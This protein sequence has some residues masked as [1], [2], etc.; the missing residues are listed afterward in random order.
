[1]KIAKHPRQKNL[2]VQVACDALIKRASGGVYVLVKNIRRCC[3]FFCHATAATDA[4]PQLSHGAHC[5]A[6]GTPLCCHQ[7]KTPVA[8]GGAGQLRVWAVN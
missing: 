5:W 3:C 6:A 1:M 8:C 2:L 4:T 7:P